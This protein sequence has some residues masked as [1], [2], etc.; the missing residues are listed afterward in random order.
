MVCSARILVATSSVDT[1]SMESSI[2]CAI[3]LS[4]VCR[5][6]VALIAVCAPA[7]SAWISWIDCW[8]ACCA[9]FAP[10]RWLSAV[11]CPL[12]FGLLA[13][14]VTAAYTAMFCS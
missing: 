4:W 6:V 7:N 2:V 11:L 9:R 10:I 3:D 5:S 1:P 13:L 8:P 14:V 12:A